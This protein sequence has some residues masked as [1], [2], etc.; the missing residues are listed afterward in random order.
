MSGDGRPV[1][2]RPRGSLLAETLCLAGLALLAFV[3]I[4]PSQVSGGGLGLDPGFLPRVCAAAV[5]VLVLAD[6]TQRLLRGAHVEVYPEGWG[7]LMRISSLAILGAIVL[8]FAGIAAAALVT[9]PVGM[10]GLGERRPLLIASTTALVAGLL[11]L[12]QR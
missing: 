6:G 10:L 4:I 3:W 12:F 9:I 11:F 8:Q 1:R 5:G 7:A 2:L